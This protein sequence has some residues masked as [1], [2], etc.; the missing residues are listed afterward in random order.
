MR[1]L[2]LFTALVALALRASEVVVAQQQ[3]PARISVTGPLTGYDAQTGA[4][5]ARMNINDMWARGGP[6]W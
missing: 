2:T 6:S 5:P 1:P 4:A 3:Q